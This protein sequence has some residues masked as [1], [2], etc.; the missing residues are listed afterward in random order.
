MTTRPRG[1]EAS[2]RVRRI[3]CDGRCLERRVWRCFVS[4][5]IW[6][7]EARAGNWA[8]SLFSERGIDF[9][10]VPRGAKVRHQFVLT[11]PAAR[12]GEH[13]GRACLVWVHDRAGQ[14]DDW[15]PPAARR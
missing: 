6:G 9:G 4:C 2:V 8:E 15:F 5:G 14:H 7:V 10:A 3:R 12:A 13:S 11:Q 1:V